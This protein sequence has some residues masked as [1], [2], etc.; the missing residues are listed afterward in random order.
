MNVN[1][2]KNRK[3]IDSIN[4]TFYMLR[5]KFN[6][7]LKKKFK[8]PKFIEHNHIIRSYHFFQKRMTLSLSQHQNPLSVLWKELNFKIK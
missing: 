7:I 4:S 2:H 1:Y 6:Q 3:S 8:Q 5:L